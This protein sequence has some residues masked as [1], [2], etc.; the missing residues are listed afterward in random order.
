MGTNFY[1]VKIKKSEPV[2]EWQDRLKEEV[3][4]LQDKSVGSI[5][6]HTERFI[7][8]NIWTINEQEKKRVAEE[9]QE[10]YRNHIGKRSAAGLYC[11]DCNLTLCAGG[12][13]KIHY[14]NTDWYKSCQSCKKKLKVKEEHN[15]VMI[16]LGFA[17]SKPEKPKGVNSCSSFS[18]AKEPEEIFKICKENHDKKIIVDEYG[19]LSTCQEFMD[20]LE[21]NC[22]VRFTNSIGVEFC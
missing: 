2:L 17:S 8:N 4:L 1:W 6:D 22:P 21:T 5:Y 12:N 15:S 11:W 14:G 19:S 10:E 13:D 3:M 20:M 16:E 7:K 18:W 9:D